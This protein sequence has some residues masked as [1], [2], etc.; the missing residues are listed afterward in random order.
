M[1]KYDD[2]LD[3]IISF[4]D[5][6]NIPLN[7]AWNCYDQFPIGK[8]TKYNQYFSNLNGGAFL[9]YLLEAVAFEYK[10]LCLIEAIVVDNFM[11]IEYYFSKLELEIDEDGI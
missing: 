10:T 1:N 3:R 6:K 7:I 5:D 4:V 9:N 2:T 11:H 8:S